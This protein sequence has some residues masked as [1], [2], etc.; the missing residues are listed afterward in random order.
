MVSANAQTKYIVRAEYKKPVMRQPQINQKVPLA[1]RPKLYRPPAPNT[2]ITVIIKKPFNCTDKR[3]RFSAVTMTTVAMVR[4]TAYRLSQ[5]VWK[6]RNNDTGNTTAVRI[7]KSRHNESRNWPVIWSFCCCN[8]EGILD[9]CNVRVRLFTTT[10]TLKV[11]RRSQIASEKPKAATEAAPGPLKSPLS[12]HYHTN[13]VRPTSVTGDRG[14]CSEPGR[15]TRKVA[16][17][18][19]AARCSVKP[20]AQLP[21]GQL[22]GVGSGFVPAVL[23][24]VIL[25]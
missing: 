17:V 21:G 10:E 19:T 3:C 25:Q 24:V 13:G 18:G 6:I 5:P 11:E 7:N 9:C 23:Q 1:A 14:T 4:C 20:A 15:Q 8:Q 2:S 12:L 16:A 22:C